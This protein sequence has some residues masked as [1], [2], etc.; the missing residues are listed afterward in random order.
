MNAKTA[1]SNPAD[2]IAL[3]VVSQATA[4]AH[5]SEIDSAAVERIRT[6]R[7]QYDAVNPESP[8]T[9]NDRTGVGVIDETLEHRDAFRLAK[10]IFYGCLSR[11]PHRGECTT[12]EVES[13]NPIDRLLIAHEYCHVASI[14][15]R[16]RSHSASGRSLAANVVR[17]RL[18]ERVNDLGT[19]RHVDAT[20]EFEGAT[21]LD[22]G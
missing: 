9:A 10:E 15:H 3:I 17:G 18:Q 14:K 7:R 1:T 19:I 11:T 16:G 4:R 6:I 21:Q 12:M 5:G 20:L 2:P 13:F 22:V 8:R